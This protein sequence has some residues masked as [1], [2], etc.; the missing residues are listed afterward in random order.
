MNLYNM[1]FACGLFAMMVVPIL[2][3]FGDKPDSALYWS[4]GHNAELVTVLTV[5]CAAFILVGFFGSGVPSW[6][7]WAGYRRLLTTTGR[8]PSDY[9]RMFGTG[10]VLVNI[11][12]NGLIGV[13]YILL[14][15]GDLNGPDLGRYLHHH[16]LFR[17][18]QAS[19][20]HH[21]G[22]GRSL[23]GGLRNAL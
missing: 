23:A 5:L 17:L 20:E 22:D 21:S 3:A 6:A 19:P 18:R 12:V 14:I 4:T 16:G 13:A 11:G 1:G 8:V 10:P 2:T 15:G 7:V 9:L